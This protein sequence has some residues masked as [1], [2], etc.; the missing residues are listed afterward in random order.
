M[1]GLTRVLDFAPMKLPPADL[2]YVLD[3]FD[4]LAEQIDASVD[5]SDYETESPRQLHDAMRQLLD[6]LARIA[7]D[8]EPQTEHPGELTTYGDYGLHL[9]DQLGRLADRGER[10]DL[11]RESEQLSLPFALWIVRRGGELRQLSSIVNAVS[12]FANGLKQPNPMADLYGCCCE[13]VEAASTA[14]ER[15]GST[16]PAEPWR[17]LLLNRAIVATRTH[18]PELIEPAYDAIV[19]QLPTEAERFFAEAM[20]QMAL[21]EYP[22]PVREIVRRYFMAHTKPR[23][24]H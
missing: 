11:R 4:D 8:D 6:L 1:V 15:P 20:E 13:L 23:H 21:V 12:H 19:E 2:S 9:I 14:F 16:N 22:D 10:T 17:L 7:T 3:R 24:L 18:N 5:S